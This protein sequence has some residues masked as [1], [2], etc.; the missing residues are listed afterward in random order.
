MSEEVIT[1]PTFK[2]EHSDRAA[3]IVAVAMW[4]D[5]RLGRLSGIS[6]LLE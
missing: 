4:I 3:H 6:T 1:A 5:S 2:R